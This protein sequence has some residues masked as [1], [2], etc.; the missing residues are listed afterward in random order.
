MSRYTVEV[1]EN[2]DRI[3]TGAANMRSMSVEK[4]IELLLN[5]FAVDAHSIKTEDMKEGYAE[6]G[7]LNLEWANLK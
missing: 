6:C 2:L 4:L 1:D 5:R 3:L 7:A